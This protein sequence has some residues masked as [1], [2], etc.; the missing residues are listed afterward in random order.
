MYKFFPIKKT[1]Q[2]S[3]SSKIRTKNVPILDPQKGLE[4]KKILFGFRRNL[5]FGRS[6]FRHSLYGQI[7][8]QISELSW[9]IFNTTL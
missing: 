1:I 6:D 2:A 3:L 7:D 9:I 8:V 4:M 5:D